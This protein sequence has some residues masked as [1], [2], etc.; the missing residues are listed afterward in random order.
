LLIAWFAPAAAPKLAE[1][2]GLQIMPLASIAL[3]WAAWRRCETKTMESGQ[4]RWT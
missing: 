4:A 1:F 3:F 2:T